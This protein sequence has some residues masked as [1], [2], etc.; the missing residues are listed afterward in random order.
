[1]RFKTIE[2][3]G[4]K[5]FAEKTKIYFQPGITAIVGPN[6]CGK[7][8]VSDAVRWVLGEQSAKQIRGERMED[9]IFSGTKSRAPMGMAEVNLTVTD[10]NA[11]LSSEFAA[12]DEIQITRR[13]YRSGES[14]YLI[15][16][17]PCRLSDIRELFMDT[18]MGAK[19]YSIIG[20]GN[21]AAVLNAKP[22]ERRFLFEEAAGISK[23]KA[24]K[25]EALRK[26]LRTQ[27]N[28]SRVRDIIAEVSRQKNSLNRQAKK[29]ERYKEYKD[30]I[31][32]LDLHL[33][34]LNYI[35]LNND[36]QQLEEQ[37]QESRNRETELT[38]QTDSKESRIED[39]ELEVLDGEKQ[40]DELHEE[41]RGVDSV[42][43]KKENRIEVLE[44]QIFHLK[45]LSE[46]AAREIERLKEEIA[47][48]EEG[49]VKL[50]EEFARISETN[51]QRVYDL[52][53]QEEA[54]REKLAT[55][56]EL[57]M[58]LDS[59]KGELANLMRQI[60]IQHNRIENMTRE[61]DS[62]VELNEGFH[63][64]RSDL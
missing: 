52:Q 23:Y 50:Q 55:Q 7:S 63:V 58:K 34:T 9:V 48:A 49:T 59:S 25:D 51:D 36:W 42:I 28:L 31:Q 8:N 43:S 40:L 11:G 62:L 20:Q 37:Y 29:A 10:L 56:R 6:G 27:E 57:E 22:A 64:N 16:R 19:A 54:L 30:E 44:G 38:A 61:R 35:A 5:S 33:S 24:R 4:F 14:E 15:N 26:L 2:I 13:Y 1:M 41:M 53:A 21:I 32:G 39:L 17:I 60:G 3:N 12:F 47:G 18:G 46:G 45:T